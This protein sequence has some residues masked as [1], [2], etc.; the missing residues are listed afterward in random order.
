[1]ADTHR[2][3]PGGDCI[4]DKDSLPGGVKG[5]HNPHTDFYLSFH[6]PRN[7]AETI[8]LRIFGAIFSRW[9]M[10]SPG[11]DWRSFH[12]NAGAVIAPGLYAV[13]RLL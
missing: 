13:H 12:L 1:M 10:V 2:L 4:R 6:N 11:L 9:V 5:V 8:G 7:E 3:S